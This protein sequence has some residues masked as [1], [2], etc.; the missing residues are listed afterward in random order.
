MPENVPGVSAPELRGG[1]RQGSVTVTINSN[2]TIHVDGDK[3]GD[4]EEKL[5]ENNR[6]LLQQVKDLLDKLN[7]DE[8]RCVYA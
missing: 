3:P 8:R 5:E 7:D 4:L 2:P 6:R 1:T